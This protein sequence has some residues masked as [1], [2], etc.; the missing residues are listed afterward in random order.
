MAGLNKL[1]KQAAQMQRQI[2]AIQ[3][4]LAQ[5]TVEAISG[6]GAVR[7]VARCDETIQSI[8]IQPDLL[9]P[10]EKEMVEDLVLT[11]VNAALEKAKETVQQELA[12][13]TGGLPLPGLMG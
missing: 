8:E 13:V 2:Q 1:L 5:R 4:S 12:K 6:G 9:R 3:E 10:E 7:V 11:A